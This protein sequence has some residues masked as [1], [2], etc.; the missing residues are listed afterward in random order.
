MEQDWMTEDELIATIKGEFKTTPAIELGMAFERVLEDPD[1]YQ[2][3]GGFRCLG[4]EFSETTMVKA[5]AAIPDR[6]GVWQ[7]KAEKVYG[8]CQ[9]VAKADY[10]LGAALHEVKTTASSFD[11]ERYIDSYQWRFM[12]D[13]FEPTTIWYHVFPMD[14]HGNGVAEVRSVETFAVYPYSE[15]HQDCV[16]LL[17]QFKSFVYTKGLDGVLRARQQEP[18]WAA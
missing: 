7:A 11:V 13:I 12:A 15:L 6:R 1:K 2:V 18:L 4:Y 17:H 10:L 14:D 3:P 9:V 8:D 5:F 16:D